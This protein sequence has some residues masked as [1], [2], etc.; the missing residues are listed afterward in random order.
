MAFIANEII[1]EIENQIINTR[2]FCG[3]EKRVARE[4]AAENG[5]VGADAKKAINI[6][7]FRA[8]RAWNDFKIQAGVKPKHRM[9]GI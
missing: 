9:F 1:D 8:N 6:A 5:L 2:D 4:T 3:D 7:F